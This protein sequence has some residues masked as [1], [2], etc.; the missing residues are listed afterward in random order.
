MHL[1]QGPKWLPLL[2][3]GTWSLTDMKRNPECVGFGGL[4]G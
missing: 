4:S 1:L 2:S 3:W